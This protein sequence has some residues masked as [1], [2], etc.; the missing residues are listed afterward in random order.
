MRI[1]S[2][3]CAGAFRKKVQYLSNY[4]ADI[5]V[6]QECEHHNKLKIPELEQYSHLDWIG[7]GLNKKGL[8]I[9]AKDNYSFE[10]LE[11]S[12]EQ[13]KYILPLRIK[14]SAAFNL[15]GVWTKPDP[16]DWAHR[17]IGQVWLAL[18][19]YEYLL[20]QNWVII[21][22]FNSNQIWDDEHRG[23]SH[24]DVTGLLNNH[25]IYSLYHASTHEPQG[26]ESRP[27]FYWRKKDNSPYHIDYCFASENLL[28]G[29]AKITI[30]NSVEFKEHYASASDHVPLIV[31]LTL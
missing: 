24:T 27:T 8:L 29:G 15:M 2:W 7:S 16:L 23:S 19:R 5:L 18:S 9:A 4:D 6:I 12:S 28:D 17:Y 10:R 30:P 14:S 11:C 26:H 31:D 1:I 13:Y 20:D 3:N 22:D 25:G 21:G